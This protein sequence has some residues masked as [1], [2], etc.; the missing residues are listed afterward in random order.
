MRSKIIKYYFVYYSINKEK[1]KVM[2]VKSIKVVLN[3]VLVGY[4]STACFGIG[5][6]IIQLINYIS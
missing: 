6:G 3:V 5:Y 4:L 2:T 1:I